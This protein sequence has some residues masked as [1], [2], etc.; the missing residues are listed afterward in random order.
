VIAVTEQRHT[1]L[2]RSAELMR[3]A[4]MT[5]RLSREAL[6]LVRAEAMRQLPADALA[7]FDPTAYVECESSPL[8]RRTPR[9]INPLFSQ[10]G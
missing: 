3:I 2:W 5:G 1:E 9:E 7:W 6:A 4:V 8:P 10:V